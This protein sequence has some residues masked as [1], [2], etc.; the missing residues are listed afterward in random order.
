MI[1]YREFTAE[2]KSYDKSIHCDYC[3]VQL[4]TQGDYCSDLCKQKDSV[5]HKEDEV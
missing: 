5:W 4:S 1:T 3:G 2:H